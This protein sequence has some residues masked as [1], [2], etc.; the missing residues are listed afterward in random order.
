MDTMHNRGTLA[1][2]VVTALNRS[3]GASA[4]RHLTPVQS[5][6]KLVQ[7]QLRSSTAG[8]PAL[9]QPRRGHIRIDGFTA[10]LV[11]VAAVGIGTLAGTAVNIAVTAS[12]SMPSS[13]GLTAGA[14]YSYMTSARWPCDEP[15]AVRI[16]GPA[17]KGAGKAVERAVKKLAATTRL[18]VVVG[19][20]Y[21]RWPETESQTAGEIVIYYVDPARRQVDGMNFRGKD[22]IGLGGPRAQGDTIVSG[23]VSIRTD[24]ESTDPRTPIGRR[25]IFHELAHATGV[26]HSH[27]GEGVMQD[28]GSRTTRLSLGD[29]FA[30][31]QVGCPRS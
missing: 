10:S 9:L 22:Y 16:A 2:G 6:A 3:F 5:K 1:A 24:S 12:E 23:Q 28:K 31:R 14:D 20:R 13:V 19:P 15:I 30:L 4:R 26:G 7:R 8:R 21:R 11:S 18:D 27:N 29:R 17:P 25:V